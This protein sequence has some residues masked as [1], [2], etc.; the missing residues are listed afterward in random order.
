MQWQV[1]DSGRL[2]P[3]AIMEKDAHLLRHLQPSSQPC[4]HLYEWSR[5]C[6]TYGYFTDPA[7]YLEPS[8]LNHHQLDMARRPTGG[9]IIFHL[10]DLAFSL[11]IPSSYPG[12]SVNTLDNYALINR[13]I[14]KAVQQFT[15]HSLKPILLAEEPA[16]EADCHGFCMAKP[17]Q[18]D[19]IIQGRKVGGAAQ[20]RTKLGLLHQGSLSLALP[21]IA[22]LQDVLK[23]EQSVVS[24]MQQHSFCL[25]QDG[26]TDQEL[27]EARL[28]L[29]E[30][31]KAAVMAT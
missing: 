31:I 17:T 2:P 12:L 20:R 10:T 4:L 27:C 3:A 11:L 30:L 25:L 16:C 1:I 22:L 19:L 5:P 14:A 18:Y 9:G 21:P 23:N 15:S 24:A 8:A 28:I 29:K 7:R 13:R 26:W 6:L